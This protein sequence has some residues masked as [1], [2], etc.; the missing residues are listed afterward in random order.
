MTEKVRIQKYLSQQGVLSRRQAEAYLQK[1]WIS[2]N[3]EVVTEL[4]TKIDPKVDVVTLHDDAQKAR[5][6]MCTIAFHKP[7]GVVTNCPQEGETEI[8]DL[9][10]QSYQHLHAIGR[11]DKD[12]EGLILMT[13]DGVFA[14]QC[15]DP[16][17]GHEREYEVWVSKLFSDSM[18]EEMETGLYILGKQTLPTQIQ[19]VGS[20]RFLM[21]MREGKN[22]QIRRMVQQVGNGVVRLKRI[23][24]GSVLL[25]GLA[26]GSFRRIDSTLELA[27]R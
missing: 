13:S 2:V 16:K 14:K 15:L 20:R 17:K 11:L 25:G 8:R 26:S 12:S 10:P 6:D 3:G 19:I 22:R 7:R 27:I 1:G 24:F 18:K 5:E 23:R 4:G 21:V 9:L